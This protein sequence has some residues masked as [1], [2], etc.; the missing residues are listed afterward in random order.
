MITVLRRVVVWGGSAALA[1]F[2]LSAGRR[3]GSDVSKALILGGGLAA[4]FWLAN[5]GN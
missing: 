5:R 2:G 1:A 3:V 4:A